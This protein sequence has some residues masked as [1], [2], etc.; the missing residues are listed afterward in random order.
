MPPSISDLLWATVPAWT[1][2]LLFE[3]LPSFNFLRLRPLRSTHSI[4][5]PSRRQVR[6][7]GMLKLRGGWPVGAPETGE[8][9]KGVPI[10]PDW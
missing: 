4:R 1:I 9:G 3:A 8:R 7:S 2:H 5:Q 10:S 6:Q